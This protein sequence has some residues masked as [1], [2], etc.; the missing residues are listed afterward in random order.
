M[1]EG[2]RR[3]VLDVLRI[4]SRRLP[5]PFPRR[6]RKRRMGGYGA[7]SLGAAMRGIRLSNR[8]EDLELTDTRPTAAPPPPPRRRRNNPLS[9]ALYLLRGL[10]IVTRPGIRAYV[11]VPL[12]I[13]VALFALLIYLGASWLGGLVER[14]LP[15]WLDFLGWMLV[16]VFVLAALIAGFFTFNLVANLVAA[17]F[18]GLLAEAV[19]RH[20]TGRPPPSGG[21]WRAFLTEFVTAF[22]AEA[23]KLAYVAVRAL[24]LLVLLLIPGVNVVASIAWMV[25]GAWMLAVTY[26]DYPM[27]NHGIG[28]AEVRRRLRGRR[29]LGLGF[30]GAVMAALAVP[31][32]NFLVIP[33]AVAGATAMWVEQIDGAGPVAAGAVPPAR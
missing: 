13:N 10:A 14:M 24:P 16:P 31:V 22:A 1:P 21:G 8:P 26:V 2:V 29:L 23:R 18:N 5:R 27:A 12:S 30:G 19:E 7:S 15:D 28:F 17:P 9:G 6:R 33:C 3:I 32:L 11:A 20:L 25:L 4:G